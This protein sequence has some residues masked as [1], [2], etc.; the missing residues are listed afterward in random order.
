MHPLRPFV[1]ISLGLLAACAGSRNGALE[2]GEAA[3]PY[4][5]SFADAAGTR[6][7]ADIDREQLATDLAAVRILWLGD[8]HRSSRL[9]ALQSELL[10]ELMH[11][12]IAITLVLEAIGTQDGPAVQ[13]FLKHRISLEQL[14][15]TM[16]QRW[17]GSWLDDLEL[18]VWFYRSLLTFA[19]A[20][21][22]PVV[23]LEPTPRGRLDQRD[24]QMARVVQ[25][26]AQADPDRLIVVVVGQAHLLGMGAL[27]ARTGLPAITLGGEPTAALRAA[28]PEQAERS[29]LRRSDTGLL[30]FS[31]LCRR[32]D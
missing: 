28:S 20:N 26:A 1:T 32:A 31:E 23:P 5:S 24:A 21:E 18:D 15:A 8:Q 10:T 12:G 25:E 19:A 13:Q 29:L 9:H 4:R 14:R 3:R 2:P 17:Q 6:F 11:R 30:W 27:V 22:L 7:V 16:R